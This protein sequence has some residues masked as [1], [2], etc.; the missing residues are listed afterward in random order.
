M[1][2]LITKAAAVATDQGHFTAIAAA[3]S[4]DRQGDQIVPGAFSNTI[5][6]WRESGKLLPL[7]YNHRADA[8]HI[9]GAVLPDKMAETDQG[10]IV[11]GQLDLDG[12]ERA[13]EVWRS[14]KNGVMSLSFGYAVTDSVK[15]GD[16]VQE[17]REIDLYEV[18]I[19]P[20]PANFDTRIVQ[21]KAATAHFDDIRAKARDEMYR[22]LTGAVDEAVRPDA[23]TLRKDCEAL[24]IHTNARPPVRV[25]RFEC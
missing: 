12:S 8:D 22:L 21:T 20:A 1:K 19:V 6:R 18:S 14:M 10:L 17:L 24:G 4:V 5:A 2:Y 13:R 7:H 15:R 3:W 9:I 25:A 23:T 16:G 11:E